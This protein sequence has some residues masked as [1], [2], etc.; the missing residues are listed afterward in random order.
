METAL[1]ALLAARA[2]SL[3]L[4]LLVTLLLGW[5][6]AYLLRLDRIGRGAGLLARWLLHK[7]NRARRDD[8]TRAWRGVIA[9]F[10]LV[11][12]AALAGWCAD[13]WL[14]WGFLSPLLMFTASQQRPSILAIWRAG[15]AGEL[16]LQMARPHYIFADTHA[17]VRFLILDHGRRFQVQIVGVI[18]WYMLG[19]SAAAFAYL[20]LAL[21]AAYFAPADAARVAFGT[22]TDRLFHAANLLPQGL[23]TALLAASGLFVPGARPFSA[24]RRPRPFALFLAGLMDVALGGPMPGPLGGERMAWVGGGTPKPGLRQLTRWLL[25]WALALAWLMFALLPGVILLTH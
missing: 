25:V 23:A 15:R 22:A 5:P 19:G 9:T 24:L 10:L 4:G 12:P 3:W 14:G 16:T 13:R 21:C 2:E 6:L 20:A 11:V 8:A 7:L 1:P 18:C 17:L